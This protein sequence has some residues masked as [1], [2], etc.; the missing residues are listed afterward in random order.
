MDAQPHFS[1][2][3]ELA[4]PALFTLLGAGI[5]FFTGELRDDRKAKRDKRAFLQAIGMELD[6][7]GKQL[8]AS[9]HE[10][11]DS[12]DRV[13]GNSQTGPQFAAALRTSV[14]TSQIGKL[15]DVGDPLL[16]EIIHFY[17]DLGTLEKTVETANDVG[18]E[19]SRADI[20]P[21]SRNA[22]DLDFYQ[23]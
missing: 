20:F 17:S 19:F 2:L 15:R 5:G 18:A 9:L 22:F 3:H 6:A 14:F 23:H 4:I 11:R 1:W 21:A 12:T 13:R 10:V 8:D 7:L 16:I